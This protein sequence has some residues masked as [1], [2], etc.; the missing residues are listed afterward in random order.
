MEA[1]KHD[2]EIG[3]WYKAKWSIIVFRRNNEFL[4]QCYAYS[5]IIVR[6]VTFSYVSKSEYLKLCFVSN[7]ENRAYVINNNVCME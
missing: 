6:T 7:T 4:P 2:L 1:T 5:S 3:I